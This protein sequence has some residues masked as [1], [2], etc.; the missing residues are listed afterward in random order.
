MTASLRHDRH[1]HRRRRRTSRRAGPRDRGQ[2]TVELALGLPVLL[3][4]L[5]LVVQAGLVVAD[6][7]AVVHAAREAARAVAVDG[8]PGAAAAAV[9]DAGA[10]QCRAS[11]ARPAEVGATLRVE[12]ICPSRTEVALVGPLLPDATVRATAAMRVER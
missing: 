3:I 8:R 7:V 5:L 12:V 6:H 2:A 4:G 1:R 11:V 10:P 9:A